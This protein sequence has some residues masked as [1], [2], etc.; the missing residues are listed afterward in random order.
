MAVDHK[1]AIIKI[2]G[3]IKFISLHLNE[4]DFSPTLEMIIKEMDKIAKE[5]ETPSA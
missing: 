4:G 1:E 2:T 3:A 5:I